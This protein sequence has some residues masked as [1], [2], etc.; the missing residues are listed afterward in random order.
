[1]KKEEVYI[2]P[3]TY[4]IERKDRNKKM[5]HKSFVLWFTG[6]SGSGKSTIANE[7]EK[8]LFDLGI[9]T[10]LLDGDNVRSGL[11]KGLGFSAED[12]NENIRRVAEVSKLMVDAGL[13]TIA[14]FV[15][16]TFKDRE[17]AK[18]VVGE[19]DFLE[20]FIDTP[21][22]I[23]EE[24]D[25]KGLYAKARKGEISNFTGINAPF[26]APTEPNVHVKT[27]G[28][29]VKECVEEILSKVKDVLS[30]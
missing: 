25:V 9:S 4:Q 2:V 12:R 23:C 11:N 26:D 20:V 5:S 14:A 29:M 24:R 17:L 13:V 27:E 7:L 3:H 21:L 16:P 19:Q 6:L 15:S 28:R 30:L 1:M 22:H 10:Y 18:G 8:A